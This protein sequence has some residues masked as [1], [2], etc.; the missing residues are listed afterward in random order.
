[1]QVSGTSL[2]GGF[3]SPGGGN[4]SDIATQLQSLRESQKRILLRR[5]IGFWWYRILLVILTGLLAGAFEPYVLQIWK[6]AVVAVVALIVL[7]WLFR[8]V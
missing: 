7:F 1:M 6:Y 2:N 5:R 8:R 4:S 3:P